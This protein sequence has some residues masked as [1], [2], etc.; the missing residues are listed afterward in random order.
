VPGSEREKLTDALKRIAPQAAELSS[1]DWW[2]HTQFMV[3]V[4][5]GHYYESR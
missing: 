3:G 1:P 5:I 4:C 2:L